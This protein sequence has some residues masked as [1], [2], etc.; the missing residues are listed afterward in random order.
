MY[1]YLVILPLFFLCAA[2]GTKT[3]T[4]SIT[5][6]QW[7]LFDYLPF[8]TEYLLYADLSEIRKAKN[9]EENF[10]SSLPQKPSGA[11]LKKFEEETGTGI[12]KGI[13]EV[14]IANT[15]EDEAILVVRFEKNYERVKRYFDKSPDF[16]N[17]DAP[18]VF[19]IRDKP[20]VRV[21]FPGENMMIV[22]NGN[23]YT[24]LLKGVESKTL[25]TNENFISI[26]NN[27]KEK[28]GLWMATDKGAFAAGIFDRLAGKDSKFLSPEILSS[29]DNFTISAEYNGGTEIESVLGC[30]SAG[31]AYLLASAVNGAI[32]MNVLSQKNYRLGKLFEKMDVNR[33]GKLI[34]FHLNLS[35]DELNDIQQLTK[36]ENPG[37]KSKGKLW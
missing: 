4:D 34:R 8:N 10:I 11:W 37:K 15:R 28:N 26:I 3:K 17:T 18:G 21:Y 31:N 32:A 20:S 1:R 19:T 24:D 16:Q 25:K 13:K 36:L 23:G 9:G 14:V 5:S 22:S 6:S 12:K 29:I 2:C 35:D 30:S 27:I 33:E 7:E